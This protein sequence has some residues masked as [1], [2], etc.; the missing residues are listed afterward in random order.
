MATN[1]CKG[2]TRNV[3]IKKEEIDH[4]LLKNNIHDSKIVANEL[5]KQRM[6]TCQSCPSLM[7]GSTCAHSGCLV[8]Y[9]AK[10]TSKSCPSPSGAKW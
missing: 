7:Y 4:I 3:I 8:E 2:C 5:F 1:V 10:F 9:R 6:D